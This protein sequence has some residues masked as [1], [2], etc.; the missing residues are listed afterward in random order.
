MEDTKN[1]PVVILCGGKGTRMWPLTS[2]IPKPLINI[3]DKAVM[4]HLMK[5]Y[6][7]SGYK[8][9]ILCLGHMGDK[10]REYFENPEN[11]ESNWNI[12]MVDTG[13]DVDKSK[14]VEAVKKY[15]KTDN[16]LVTYGD[17]LSAVDVEELVKFHI[18]KNKVV[19]LTSV[20]LY[21]QFGVLDINENYEVKRFR[22]KPRLNEYW[23]NGGFYVFNKK[24][25]DILHFGELEDE[26]MKNLA[27]KREVASFKFEGF[28]KCM[29]TSK[30]AIS[31]NKM[32]ESGDTPWINW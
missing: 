3:G 28:W 4:W 22:E 17:D 20:P 12:I 16:F 5:K 25:F 8:N 29:N 7:A 15:I 27:E 2:E 14:R 19:T 24:I 10:I 11:R 26:V 21:S 30:D 1:W 6:S 31:F 9:F 18:E 13:K 23:I 32:Y